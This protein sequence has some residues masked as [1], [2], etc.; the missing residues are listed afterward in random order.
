MIAP[1]RD[2][3]ANRLPA[4]RRKLA[5]APGQA[6]PAW[7]VLQ[8]PRS[9]VPLV[10][11]TFEFACQ[12]ALLFPALAGLRV[13]FRSAPFVACLMLL[14]L[15][16]KTPDHHPARS[17]AVAMVAI[18]AA[19]MLH[20]STNSPVAGGATLLLNLAILS[21]LFWVPRLRLDAA[22]IR[23]LFLL[24]WVFQT[25]SAV[26]G[27]L[28]VY[29]PGRFEPATASVL[30]DDMLGSL[31]ITLAD[32][33]RIFRPMG[34]TDAPGGAGIGGMYSVLFA[35]ALWLERPRLLFR[36]VLLLSMGI[37]LFALYICQVRSLLVMLLPALVASIWSQLSELR[38]GR[39]IAIAAP[40][41][42]TAVV[43]L[44]FAMTVGGDAVTV[45]LNTLIAGDP[46]SL[47]ISNRGIFLQSTLTDLLPQYPFGAGLGRWGMMFSYFGDRY[48]AEGGA[49]WAEIQWTGWLLD[50]GVP[51]MLAAGAGMFMALREGF[52][53]ATSKASVLRGL[54]GL[55]GMLLGYSMGIVALTFSG[56]PFAS[57]L[58]LDFWLLNAAVVAAVSQ[59]MRLA[60][61]AGTPEVQGLR[62]S[63]VIRP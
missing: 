45:R 39:A 50:G 3:G 46:G 60:D 21:P 42:A 5:D 4:W 1:S 56:C 35:M 33:S 36:V 30:T 34:L 54:S 58:G 18:L 6:G 19:S 26:T 7:R 22:A 17:M 9:H 55:S 29:F 14:M 8:L 51:L 31:K 32:G 2:V 12:V 53:A 57:T 47:Y 49:I 44:G 27:A 59:A 61:E 10:F 63:A 16:G 41:L 13:L 52:R 25:A 24:M 38:V 48:N 62:R 23:R 11:L 40:V 28:Q 15:P 20:P 37:G 43:A